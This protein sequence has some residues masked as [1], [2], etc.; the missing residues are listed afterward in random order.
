GARGPAGFTRAIVDI[1]SKML[2]TTSQINGKFVNTMPEAVA[3]I[4]AE[5]AKADLSSVKAH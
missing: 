5:R 1:V 3:Y 4:Q 2:G